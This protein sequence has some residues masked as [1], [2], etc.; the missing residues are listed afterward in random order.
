MFLFAA[1]ASVV[2]M[3]VAGCKAG[4]NYHPPKTEVS[5][6]YV[7][8]AQTN[9]ET[10][11]IA[12]AWWHG[13]NDQ[14]LDRLVERALT[15]NH[16]LRIATA[17]VREARALRG[18]EMSG[19]FPVVT[20]N[21]GYTQSL[22]SKDSTPIPLTK[23]QRE[24]HLYNAGFDA[25]WELDLFGH[26]RRSVEAASAEVTASEADR[27]DVMISLIAEVARN[28]CELRGAQLE[29]DVARR[30][31]EVQRETMEVTEAKLKVGRGTDLDLTRALAQ[32]NATLAGIPPLEGAVKHSIYRLGVLTGSQPTALEGELA[33]AAPIPE[34]PAL[35][36]IGNPADLLRRRPDI[37]A[38]ERRLASATA[39]IGVATADLFPRVFFNGSL[40]VA[41]HNISGLNEGDAKNYSFGPQIT[42]AALDLGHVSARIRAANAQADALLAGYEKTVLT[43]LE[44]TE[45]ALVDFGREQARREYLR[46]SVR[47]ATEAT[48]LAKQRY[49]AGVS[50]FLQVLDTQRTQLAVEADLAQSEAR[51][52][53]SLVAIYKALGGGWEIEQTTAKDS[54]AAAPKK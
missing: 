48:R 33:Q 17:R 36:N 52:A 32:L 9:T 53:T 28:Y 41:A 4:P 37:R 14:E 15:A 10:G 44:E 46:L 19:A 40:G 1:A 13:F 54:A 34:L 27:Q 38:A 8:G 50:D 12:I 23:E 24:L 6:S 30:N 16:D 22:T 3:L 43:A 26:V 29:L 42:W 20:A 25:T 39:L 11:Q 45:N 7:N 51:T 31:V 18:F 21:A 35:V 47:S 5:A 49:E 2:G